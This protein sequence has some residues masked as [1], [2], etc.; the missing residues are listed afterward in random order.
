MVM[1]RVDVDDLHLFPV[2]VL[3]QRADIVQVGEEVEPFVQME[4]QDGLDVTRLRLVLQR[5][6]LVVRRSRAGEIHGVPMPPEVTA[7][8]DGRLGGAGPLPVAEQMQDPRARSHYRDHTQ[9]LPRVMRAI[10]LAV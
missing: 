2:N 3:R 10:S 7:E 9:L 1:A 4:V 8:V 6:R 5:L